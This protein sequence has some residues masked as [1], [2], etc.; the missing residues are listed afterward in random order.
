MNMKLSLIVCFLVGLIVSGLDAREGGGFSAGRGGKDIKVSLFAKLLCRVFGNQETE[1]GTV[2]EYC[3]S[4]RAE[5]EEFMEPIEADIKE[6]TEEKQNDI[7]GTIGAVCAAGNF[8]ENS[9]EGRLCTKLGEE[10]QEG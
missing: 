7:K 9:I 10:P 4:V 2:K 3:E 6:F 1:D 5:I 8:D